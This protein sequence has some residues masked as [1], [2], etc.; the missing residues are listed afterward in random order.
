[1]IGEW[2]PACSG[3]EV[4]C[5]RIINDGWGTA[6]IPGAHSRRRDGGSRDLTND[7]VG[8]LKIGEEEKFVA[9]DAPAGRAA[10]LIVDGVRN[11][12]RRIREKVSRLHIAVVV[13]LEHAPMEG[14]GAR[15]H[16]YIDGRS[17]NAPEFR[18]VVR[19]AH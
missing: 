5:H 19:G 10:V 18:I 15:L 6:E 4:S 2:S 8:A 9:N 1:M 11:F 16:D 7:V 12:G 17:A 14:V 3:K 13:I